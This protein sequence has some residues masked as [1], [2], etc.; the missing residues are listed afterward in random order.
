MKKTLFV[1]VALQVFMP[2]D[3]AHALAVKGRSSNPSKSSGRSKSQSSLA[4]SGSSRSQS[5][6]VKK[7]VK[8]ELSVLKVDPKAKAVDVTSNQAS[9]SPVLNLSKPLQGAPSGV[10][11]PFFAMNGRAF[12]ARSKVNPSG[13]SFSGGKPAIP[14]KPAPLTLTYDPHFV[15][16]A[17]QQGVKV[18]SVQPGMVMPSRKLSF[19]TSALSTARAK[20]NTRNVVEL[21]NKR[22]GLKIK[23]TYESNNKFKDVVFDMQGRKVGDISHNTKGTSVAR[24]YETRGG[25]ERLSQ[26]EVYNREGNLV[27]EVNYKNGKKNQETSHGADGTG[28]MEYGPSGK[29]TSGVRRNAYGQK[30]NSI[31]SKRG[32]MVNKEYD[33]HGKVSVESVYSSRGQLLTEIVYQP[34]GKAA[35]VTKFNTQGPKKGTAREIVEFNARGQK[36]QELSYHKDGSF[37][38]KKY[39]DN[40]LSVEKA[41]DAHNNTVKETNY[42]LQGNKYSEVSY[43][44]DGGYTKEHFSVQGAKKGKMI[45]S[46]SYNAQQAEMLA[47]AESQ[48][49]TSS[50]MIALKGVLKKHPKFDKDPALKEI[51]SSIV[52]SGNKLTK[53]QARLIEKVVND[54]YSTLSSSQKSRLVQYVIVFKPWNKQKLKFEGTLGEHQVKLDQVLIRK[55]EKLNAKDRG[56]ILEGIGIG[57]ISTPAGVESAIA[58]YAA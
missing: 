34:N 40:K 32:K 12:Q 44:K 1:V 17:R 49:L 30:I 29:I 50:S 42:D 5:P 48:G 14:A 6:S 58:A 57:S 35:S 25:K 8:A 24:K 18:N 52:V 16:S 56:T 13:I 22:E 37:T 54:P 33:A 2:C 21:V 47:L 38:N 45:G 23:R 15:N 39:I 53:E 27:R 4:R 46:E 20:L 51:V 10:F 19:D 43:H 11:N 3:F 9:T 7:R 55:G 36:L 26:L 28:V 31:V 41:V